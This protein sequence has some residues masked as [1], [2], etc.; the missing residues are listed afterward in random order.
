MWMGGD[1]SPG[2]RVDVHAWLEELSY[3]PVCRRQID[4]DLTPFRS[5]DVVVTS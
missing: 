3:R 4:Y 2:R 1:C 5:L